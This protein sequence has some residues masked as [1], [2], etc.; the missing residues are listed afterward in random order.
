MAY[1]QELGCDTYLTGEA[2]MFGLLFAKEAGINL[3]VAGHYATEAPGV[4]ALSTRIAR[5][6]ALDVTFI[7]EEIVEATG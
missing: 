1:A 2:I 5:D 3:I 6:L 7:P 4:M